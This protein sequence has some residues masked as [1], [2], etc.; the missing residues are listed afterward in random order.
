M[1]TET[2]KGKSNFKVKHQC[3]LRY[4]IGL[5]FQTGEYSINLDLT[6]A[7]TAYV[8]SFDVGRKTSADHR[9]GFVFLLPNDGNKDLDASI[10]VQRETI[11]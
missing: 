2:F 11:N 6:L 5:N 8:I 1:V 7:R 10:K 4:E 9:G 3:H